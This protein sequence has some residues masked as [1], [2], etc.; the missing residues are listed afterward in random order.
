MPW[1]GLLKARTLSTGI[2]AVVLNGLSDVLTDVR[3]PYPRGLKRTFNVLEGSL[4]RVLREPYPR[5]LK[6]DCNT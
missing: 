1:E 4:K 2:E 3:E 6:R 5:G